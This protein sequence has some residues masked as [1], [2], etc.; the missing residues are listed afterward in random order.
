MVLQGIAEPFIRH[1]PKKWYKFIAD[2][3]EKTLVKH[4][5]GGIEYRKERST[6]HGHCRGK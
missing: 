6:P 5:R 2:G 3:T 1:I 4:R